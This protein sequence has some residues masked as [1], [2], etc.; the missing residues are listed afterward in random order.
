MPLYHITGV[1][2]TGKSTICNELSKRGYEAYDIDDGAYAVWVDKETDK[3]VQFPGE[4]KVDM[5]EWFKKHRW[6]IDKAKVADL[7]EKAK[8][9]GNAIY[10]CGSA[11]GD[12]GVR[13]YFAKRFALV[14]DEDT[15]KYRL[16]NR[17]TNDFGKTPEELAEVIEWH[18]GF[19]E[20]HKTRG[21]VIIDAAQ[22]I[23]SVVDQIIDISRS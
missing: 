5:H 2:G 17:T 14:I 18:N 15:L 10:L 4:D 6:S 3:P 22:P 16:A 20:K 8:N 9:T 11:V 12:G 13:Q 19:E 7:Y 23:G 21:S 1:S